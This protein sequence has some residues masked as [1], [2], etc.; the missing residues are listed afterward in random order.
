[1][2]IFQTDCVHYSPSY[3]IFARRILKTI[4]K[5]K[6]YVEDYSVHFR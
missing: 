6:Y 1:M 3:A 4:R 2:M 5:E